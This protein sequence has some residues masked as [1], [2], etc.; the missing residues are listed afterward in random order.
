MTPAFKSLT[1]TKQGVGL[2]AKKG[3]CKENM[4]LGGV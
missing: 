1:H 2:G 3:I 4:A